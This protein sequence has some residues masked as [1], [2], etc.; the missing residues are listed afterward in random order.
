M[1]GELDVRAAGLHADLADAGE[2]E[3][4]HDLVFAIRQRLDGGDGDRVAG[5]HAHGVE[6]FDGADD[7]AVVR[8]VAHDLHLEL[9]PAEQR[10]LDEHLG[11]GRHVEAV[12]GDG[13]KLLLVVSNAA[14]SAA[15]RVGGAD[16][17]WQ[18]AD[19][20]GNDACFFYGVG[21]TGL[22]QVKPDLEHSVLELEPVL[23]FLDG[24][25]VRADHAH[26]VLRQRAGIPQRHGAIQSRLA[27]ERRQQRIGLFEDDDLLDDLGIDRLDVG[28]IRE[29]RV[30]HDRGRIGIDE[31]HLIAFL[32]QGLAGLDARVVELTALADDDGAG[33]DDENGFDG[34]VFG[35]FGRMKG[36]DGRMKKK[37]AAACFL[38]ESKRRILSHGAGAV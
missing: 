13:F 26:A 30:R 2:G 25:R 28:P 4:A 14:A 36:E 10:F 34:G 35:H 38:R 6:V 21:H 32:A 1:H 19:L 33:A 9:L 18:R 29:L 15:E 37:G 7:D 17:E 31:H 24:L 5:M 22:R 11:D 8:T 3:V 20:C 23:S 12:R 16:D 27:A